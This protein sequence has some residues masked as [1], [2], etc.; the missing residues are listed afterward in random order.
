MAKPT[1]YLHPDNWDANHP[2]APWNRSEC[3][4]EPEERTCEC[5]DTIL[6]TDEREV[7][8]P[9]KAICDAD[10]AAFAAQAANANLYRNEQA[11]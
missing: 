4:H 3:D 8:T 7:C 6:A 10:D 9:C 2:L 1:T 5:C 11:A